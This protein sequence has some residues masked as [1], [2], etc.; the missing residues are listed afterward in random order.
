MEYW[1]DF[2][3]INTIHIHI[4]IHISNYYYY[5]YNNEAINVTIHVHQWRG[6]LLFRP[7]NLMF[8]DLKSWFVD[9]ILN[10]FYKFL[11]IISITHLFLFLLAITNYLF[12]VLHYKWHYISCIKL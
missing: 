7:E 4:N 11:S 2:K 9:I 10:K 3:I 1:V 6:N 5:W 12:D 8:Y